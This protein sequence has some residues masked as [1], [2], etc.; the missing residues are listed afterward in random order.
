MLEVGEETGNIE[1]ILMQLAENF[2]TEVDDTGNVGIGTTSPGSKLTVAG[3]VSTTTGYF[4]ASGSAVAWGRLAH[5]SLRRSA[6][7]RHQRRA[8]ASPSSVGGRLVPTV[9]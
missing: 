7:R 4:L 8:F 9:G 6:C 3:N 2:E 1:E 5:G